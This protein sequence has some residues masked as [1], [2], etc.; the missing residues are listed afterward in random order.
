MEKIS[1]RRNPLCIHFKKLGTRKDYRESCGEFICDG[2]KL[3][4]EADK[5]GADILTVLTSGHLPFPLPLSTKVYLTD[6]AL[7][8]SLS[9]LKNAQNVLFTCKMPSKNF[10]ADSNVTRV[11]LDGVQDPGNVGT[12]VRTA[13]AFGIKN[14]ILTGRCADI[15]NPK[16]IRA[17]MGAVF[18]QNI[19]CMTNFDLTELRA[20]GTQF[21]CAA[22]GEKSKELAEVELRNKVIAIGSE[23]IGL[24]DEVLALCDE[25]VMIPISPECESLNAAVAA[26]ILMWSAK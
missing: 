22:L 19:Y 24:S 15:Y 13:N 26:G 17:T 25:R 2:L 1:S 14:I 21:V 12:I 18:K 5:S 7:I 11:L 23:G 3:L 16:T 9:P 10:D 20:G 6:N 4:E 8:N